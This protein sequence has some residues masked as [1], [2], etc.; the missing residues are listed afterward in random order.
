[1]VSHITKPIHFGR[2][3][4]DFL[5]L[6]NSLR[7]AQES[8]VRTA[9]SRHQPLYS[10][11]EI[12]VARAERHNGNDDGDLHGLFTA[13]KEVMAIPRHPLF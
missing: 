11:L 2:K 4:I 9:L 7:I 6:L 8:L 5:V 1:M 12:D 13:G 10:G 3:T